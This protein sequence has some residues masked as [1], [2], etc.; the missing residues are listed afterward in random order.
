MN[1][2]NAEKGITVWTSQQKTSALAEAVTSHFESDIGVSDRQRSINASRTKTSP[3]D[4]YEAVSHDESD[5]ESFV[6][7]FGDESHAVKETPVCMYTKTE[8]DVMCSTHYVRSLESAFERRVVNN[9]AFFVL[10][11]VRP[12]LKPEFVQVHVHGPFVSSHKGSGSRRISETHYYCDRTVATLLVGSLLHLPP[13]LNASMN[14]KPVRNGAVVTSDWDGCDLHILVSGLGGK[15]KKKGGAPTRLKGRGD[16]LTAAL[17]SGA[18]TAGGVAGKIAMDVAMILGKKAA[19]ATLPAR[20]AA[21]KK[22]AKFI[23][24]KTSYLGSRMSRLVGRGDYTIAGDQTVVNSLMKGT[25]M[26]SYS[27][28]GGDCAGMVLE[29]REFIADLSTGLVVPDDPDAS[30]FPFNIQVIEMNPGIIA[31]FPWLAQIALN[32]EEYQFMGLVIEF[33]STTSPYNSSSAMGEIIITSQDN[34]TAPE[35]T[36]RS[37]LFNSE[38]STAGRLDKNLMYGI[39]TK[40]PAVPWYQVRSGPSSTPM[41][42]TDLVKVYIATNVANSFPQQSILGEVWVT[43]RVRFRGPILKPSLGSSVVGTFY[44]GEAS[45][46]VTPGF[47]GSTNGYEGTIQGTGRFAPRGNIQS[48]FLQNGTTGSTNATSPYVGHVKL[49]SGIVGEVFKLTFT[50]TRNTTTGVNSTGS[51][52]LP[53]FSLLRCQYYVPDV[54]CGTIQTPPSNTV[55]NVGSSV[56]TTQYVQSFYVQTT[57]ANPA[58]NMS[59]PTVASSTVGGG[60]WPV[61]ASNSGAIFS[62]NSSL[63]VDIQFIGAYAVSRLASST[64]STQPSTLY[65]S[66]TPLFADASGSNTSV[67]QGAAPILLN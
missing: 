1:G 46:A 13:S 58:I 59:W 10:P 60:T 25:G 3:F 24:E 36:T 22:I 19:K 49:P 35:Y 63:V 23:K 50:W 32:Y 64:L 37:Q 29:H 55:L 20:V 56:V 43:Y 30:T 9:A 26:S 51:T 65:W 2:T 34:V 21:G 44:T 47:F 11:N 33:V 15:R 52:T 57:T 5:T 42:L 18:S 27:S 38:M 54:Y 12:L 8:V 16:Y 40:N 6:M 61:S 7:Q 28:F 66:S 31:S 53:L 14:A 17:T 62:G 39:E 41:N 48:I 4:A 67:A 45:A